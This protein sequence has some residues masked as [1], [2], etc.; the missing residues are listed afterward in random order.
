MSRQ[1]DACFLFGYLQNRLFVTEWNIARIFAV[2]GCFFYQFLKEGGFMTEEEAALGQSVSLEEAS[3]VWDG[4]PLEKK[5]HFL[6]VILETFSD[7]QTMDDGRKIG[8]T[9]FYCLAGNI[10]LDMPKKIQGRIVAAYN[11]D[12]GNFK[13]QMW[14]GKK[15]S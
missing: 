14:S 9:E 4:A 6:R 10:L 7:A 11:P 8:I 5:R 12:R 15:I 1:F 13:S 2:G 3:K